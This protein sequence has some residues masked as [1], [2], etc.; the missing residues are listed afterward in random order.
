MI[1]IVPGDYSANEEDGVVS[2]RVELMG[3]VLAND[4]VVEFYTE[5]G[6]AGGKLSMKSYILVLWEQRQSLHEY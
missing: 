1:G 6:S 2:F 4:V 3:G 5:S